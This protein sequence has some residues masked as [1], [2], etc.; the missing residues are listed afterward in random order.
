MSSAR[1]IALVSSAVF[2]RS[3]ETYAYA[4]V[5][6]IVE[7]DVD[8]AGVDFGV[9]VYEGAVIRGDEGVS[10]D[11]KVSGVCVDLWRRSESNFCFRVFLVLAMI[12]A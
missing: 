6:D 7:T 10:S 5:G 3:W 12:E 11:D 2:L 8:T 1:T 9:N 4:V